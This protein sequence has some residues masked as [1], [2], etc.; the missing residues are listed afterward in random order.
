MLV[1]LEIDFET[2]YNPEWIKPRRYDFY[3]PSKN[4][5]IEMDGGWHTSDNL[6]SGQTKE[7]SKTIDDYKDQIAREHGI[8][9]IR[10]N[11]CYST[12]N[13]RFEYIKQ[14]ILVGI[15]KLFD[16]SN[17]DWNKCNEFANKNLVKEACELKKN[18]T[19]Y[20][21][22]DIAKI[23]N[24]CTATIREYL[25]IGNTNLWC[26]YNSKN[27]AILTQT[28]NVSIIKNKFSK[29]VEIFKDDISL[30]IFESC[31]DLEEQSE[32]LFGIKLSRNA[33]SAVARGKRNHHKGF[34]FKYI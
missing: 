22:G 30:G 2:E 3:I 16:L 21:T 34:I 7:E 32:K 12:F 19:S 24:V 25:K 29:Q 5:I 9:V 23:L 26:S 20:S 15:N 6:M 1:Q 8:E 10:V 31:L 17:I 14:N 11:C 18:N 27:E 13:N 28:K 4:L 33:I